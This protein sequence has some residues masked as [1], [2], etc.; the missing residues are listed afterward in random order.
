E[1][2]ILG[3]ELSGNK[4][5]SIYAVDVA[6]HEHGLH[7]GKTP[8][9]AITRVIKKMIRSTMIIMAY[10]GMNKG[11]IIFAS[12]KINPSTYEPLREAVEDIDA[13]MSKM[14]LNFSFRLYANSD[15]KEHIIEPVI[16]LSGEVEDTSELFMR[17]I[18]LYQMFAAAGRGKSTAEETAQSA[19]EIKI[20]QL[21]KT[22]FRKLFAQRK[23]TEK[24]ASSLM[25]LEYSKQTFGLSFPVL[26]RIDDRYPLSKQIQDHKGRSRYWSQKFGNGKYLICSQWYEK[27]RKKFLDWSN[28]LLQE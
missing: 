21:V 1:V 7:Y 24:I 13:L 16:Q 19:D 15:F 8:R 22:T 18:Q 3:I 20:G 4:I 10:F 26:K 9:D 12:P 27:H 11:S 2:D 5:G 23:I 28:K 6:F 25:D 14:K 17:S